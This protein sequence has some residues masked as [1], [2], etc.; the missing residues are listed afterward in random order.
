MATVTANF[1]K[2]AVDEDGSSLLLVFSIRCPDGTMCKDSYGPV[3][4][5]TTLLAPYHDGMVAMV[6]EAVRK[7]RGALQNGDTVRVFYPVRI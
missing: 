1:Q 4:A 3:P 2:V 6:R 7:K 5:D